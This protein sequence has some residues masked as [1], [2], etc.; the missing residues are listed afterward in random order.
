QHRYGRE[1]IATGGGVAQ[2]PQERVPPA[3]SVPRERRPTSCRDAGAHLGELQRALDEHGRRLVRQT[4]VV[5][6]E[7]AIRI[8]PPAVAC[9]IAPRAAGVGAACAHREED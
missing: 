8:G 6:A 7:L 5:V 4:R 3:E 9:P 2:L 1:E